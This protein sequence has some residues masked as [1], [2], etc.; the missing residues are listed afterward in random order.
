MF[1]TFSP[2]LFLQSNWIYLWVFGSFTPWEYDLWLKLDIFSEIE[3]QPHHNVGSIS[4]N[5]CFSTNSNPYASATNSTSYSTTVT[6]Q[7]L[8]G[9]P[10]V[11]RCNSSSTI[12]GKLHITR[13]FIS[14][15]RK[16]CHALR[17]RHSMK[18][19]HT[20]VLISRKSYPLKQ[21]VA[22]CENLTHKSNPNWTVW[23][24]HFKVVNCRLKAILIS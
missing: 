2:L 4:V 17:F 9:S 6:N 12:D 5:S 14:S 20:S 16:Y 3:S 7:F 24:R 11:R 21:S 10:S 19:S 22:H 18:I 8:H 13:C 15:T 23:T 1:M